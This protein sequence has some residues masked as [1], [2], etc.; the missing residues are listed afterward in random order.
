MLEAYFLMLGKTE[1]RRRRG[2]QRM[3]WLDGTTD[4]MD[5]SLSELRELVMDREAWHTAKR[6]CKESDTTERLNW[7]ELILEEQKR[8]R[9][10]VE[11]V[12]K[13]TLTYELFKVIIVYSPYYCDIQNGS[14]V[15]I[16]SGS[17]V[18][19]LQ[20]SKKVWLILIICEICD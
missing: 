11:G 15:R 17:S 8:E 12:R 9:Y 20:L 2:R 16:L 6:G 13:F 1:G 19:C 14:S 10:R 5:V 4:L 3:R 7:T 18:K